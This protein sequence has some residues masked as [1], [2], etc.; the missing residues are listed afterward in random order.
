MTSLWLWWFVESLLFI[1]VFWGLIN[2][3]PIYPLDG[4]QIAREVLLALSPRQG[5]R[6]SLVL[7]AVVAGGLAVVGLVLWR[8]WLVTLFFG[9]LAYTSYLTLQNYSR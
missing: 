7:S 3:L 9:Y 1:S 2:L 8:D 5:I 4:G 6:Q